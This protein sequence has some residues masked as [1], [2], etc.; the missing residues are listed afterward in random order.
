M[1]FL[2]KPG[3]VPGIIIGVLLVYAYHQFVSP[4]PRSPKMSI[5]MGKKGKQSGG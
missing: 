4:L 5:G 1:R 2:N 3:I